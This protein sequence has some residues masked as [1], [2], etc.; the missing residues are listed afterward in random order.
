M[1]NL[2]DCLNLS[3]LSVAAFLS[4]II[5]C[6]DYLPLR[7]SIIKDLSPS[8]PESQKAKNKIE[9][10]LSDVVVLALQNSRRLKNAYLQRIIDQQ[11]LAVAENKFNPNFLPEI[12]V[13]YRRNQFADDSN[14]K[15]E[16]NLGTTVNLIIPT[17]GDIELGWRA[18][19]EIENNSELSQ[20]LILS[21][22]QPLLRDG[23]IDVNRASIEDARLAEESNTLELISEINS[24]ITNA[25]FAYLNLFRAQ[26]RLKI[27]QLSLERAKRQLEIN[28]ALVEA[29]RIARIILVENQTSVANREVDVLAAENRLDAARLSLIQVLDLDQETQLVAKEIPEI[30]ELY[31]FDLSE[32]IP[33]ILANNPEYLRALITIKRDKLDLLLAKNDQLWDLDFQI[34]YLLNNN[35]RTESSNDV[36]VGLGLSREFG[37]L[38]LEQRVKRGEIRLKTSENNLT[39]TRENLAIEVRNADRDII[40]NFLGWQQAQRATKLSQ[41]Q[42]ENEREKLRLGVGGARQIDVLNLEDSLVE[43]QNRE[44]NA[45]IDYFSALVR[46]DAIL[47][48]TYQK[49]GVKINKIE[50]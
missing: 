34:R 28:E 39:E 16:F 4:V 18:N 47:G 27:Q 13:D 14:Q 35:T 44:L 33:F 46:L 48:V 25:I 23:G 1:S 36:R 2:S 10:N 12:S 40:D 21:F 3:R 7:A 32:Q 41:Q 37:N 31:E 5:N 6:F 20:D 17:G 45:L 19:A 43:V 15:G 22:N 9:L 8:V 29:G 26:E 49:W 11:D 38:S 30:P 42:L 24:I 50:D